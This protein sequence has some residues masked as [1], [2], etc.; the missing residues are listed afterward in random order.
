VWDPSSWPELDAPD[1]CEILIANLGLDMDVDTMRERREANYARDL[2]A[3]R[4]ER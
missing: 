2:Q 1:A 3:D 4:P